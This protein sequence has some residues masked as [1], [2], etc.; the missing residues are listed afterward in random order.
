MSSYA[1]RPALVRQA[2]ARRRS[3]HFDDAFRGAVGPA[4]ELALVFSVAPDTAPGFAARAGALP[5]ARDH[6]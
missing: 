3:L 2:A 4:A 5:G 6:W 1:D